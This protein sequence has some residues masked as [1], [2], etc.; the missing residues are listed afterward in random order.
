MQK[1]EIYTDDAVLINL[2]AL[3]EILQLLSRLT[4]AG[5]LV[6]AFFFSIC[7]VLSHQ[8]GWVLP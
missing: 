7:S 3:C 6:V 2:P 1:G 5:L 8:P 4:L